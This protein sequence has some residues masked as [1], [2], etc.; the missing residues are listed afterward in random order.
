MR[1]QWGALFTKIRFYLST[2]IDAYITTAGDIWNLDINYAPINL[3]LY[4]L[5]LTKS[6]VRFLPLSVLYL[7]AYTWPAEN[8]LYKAKIKIYEGNIWNR[9]WLRLSARAAGVSHLPSDTN[10]AGN[11]QLATSNV[12]PVGRVRF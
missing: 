11:S 8:I 10:A 7:Y 6:L 4:Q 1:L 5:I 9:C 12:A 2:N 3:L